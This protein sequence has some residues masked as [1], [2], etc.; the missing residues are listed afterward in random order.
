MKK[1]LL[2]FCCMI[3]HFAFGGGDDP[4]LIFKA[5]FDNITVIADKAAG[6]KGTRN[7]KPENLQLRM[8]EGVA[9]KGNALTLGNHENVVYSNLDNHNPRRGTV[10]F[11]IMSKNWAPDKE[12]FQIFFQSIFPGGYRFLVYKF[13]RDGYLRFVI[14]DKDKEVGVIN[15]PMKNDDW[16]PGHWHKIDAVWDE[17]MMALYL[18]G[19]IAK[20]QPYTA[21]PYLFKAPVEFLDSRPDGS[22]HLGID[23]SF[24]HDKNDVT[25]YDEFEIYDRVLSPT[26]IRANYE[27]FMPSREAANPVLAVPS[28]K[29]VVVDGLLGAEE[30]SDAACIPVVNPCRN[31]EGA[32]RFS[33]VFVKQDSENLMIGAE[34]PGGERANI[35]GNDL[36]DI[37]RGDS[38]EFHVLT[39]EK[40][41]FQFIVN[42][43]GA[44]FDAVVNRTDGVYDQARLNAGWASGARHAACKEDGRW[45]AELVIPK[46][47]IGADGGSIAAN[48]GVTVY[49]DKAFHGCWGMNSATFFDESAFGTLK[50]N[51]EASPARLEKM[52]FADGMFEV[53]CDP[54]IAVVLSGAGGV[55]IARP[56]EMP[57]WKVNLPLGIYRFSATAKDFDYSSTVVVDAPLVVDYTCFPSRRIIEAE[58]NLSGAG[59]GTRNALKSGLVTARVALGDAAGNVYSEMNVKLTDLKTTVRLALPENLE[60]GEYRIV[61]DVVDSMDKLSSFK[62]FR[63][64]DMTPY[65]LKT[66]TERTAPQPWI[67]VKQI[68]EKTFEVWNR[69][70]TFGD[71]PFPVSVVAGGEEMLAEAPRLD[72]G[73]KPVQW[74]GFKVVEGYD[75]AVH[76]TGNG[77]AGGVTFNWS[78]ELCFDGLLK[79]RIGMRPANGPTKLKQLI[80]RWSVPSEFASAMLDP[81]F[82][83]WKNADGETLRFPYHHTQDFIIWTVGREKG[84]LWW[85]GS[86]ANWNNPPGHRQFFLSRQGGTVSVQADFITREV[87]LTGEAVYTMA[88]M[89]TPGRP[90]PMRRRDFNPGQ[91]WDFLKHES[92]KVQ[93]YG[94]SE[95]P[96]AYSTEPWTGL[97]PYDPVRYLEHIQMVE[98]KGSRYMPYSQPAHTSSIEESYDYFFPEWRQKPGFPV[99]G[100]IEFKTGLRYAPEACCPHTGAGDLFVWRADRLLADFPMLPGLY[101][102][103]CEGRNCWN[104][105][106][107]CGGIDAFGQEYASS[108]LLALR[109]YFIRLK[110]VL[111]KHGKDKILFLHAHNRFIPFAHGIGDYWF[112]GEQYADAITENLEHF[113]CENIPLREYQS[114]Y[115]SPVHGSGLVLM[116]VYQITAWR[117]G[118]TQKYDIPKYTISLMTPALLHDLNMSNCYLHHKTVERWW[119]IK[120]DADLA[121]AKFHGYWFSDAAKSASEKVHVSWYEWAEPSPWTRLLVIG[122]IGRVEKNAALELDLRKLGLEG[123]KLIFHDL[124]NDTLIAGLDSLSVKPNDFRLIGIRAE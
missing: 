26:E 113:Y 119:S 87:E 20:P 11:W 36:V 42:P 112:P 98:S 81:L 75:D 59:G 77:M 123:R 7:F 27:K 51:S 111:E 102:D 43:L 41:R 70:Y 4:S 110:R 45:F 68:G 86:G 30:W 5:G 52:G 28:G 92:V 107:G 6:W 69:V 35:T 71:G 65:R 40:R 61:A 63:V 9:G 103:I 64:P 90:E 34:L 84:F 3:F 95:K 50:F 79:L 118:L 57:Y 121:A 48:F 23:G 99:G 114:A 18:D 8:H 44:M 88:F 29:G 115:Y 94:I 13:V 24:S 124:W 72:V 39:Q 38:F 54:G 109:D 33:R 49:G 16:R 82:T 67:P 73:G 2:V 25:A 96:L 116:S 21:N 15:V 74:S 108:T 85:P 31:I 106:H 76:F 19:A 100:G 89:A 62:R 105:V 80:L 53:Q 37:W 1:I 56:P 117:L 58:V 17:T 104:T 22:M 122:N 32:V 12:K 120:H 66:G 47:N 91:I 83:K 93:Y 101:Y 97:V 60:R 46:K 78:G 10:S 55:K 14:I